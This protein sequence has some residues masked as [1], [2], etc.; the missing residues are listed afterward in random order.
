[1]T[2]TPIAVS[3]PCSTDGD[4]AMPKHGGRAIRK[5]RNPA[6]MSAS[7]TREVRSAINSRSA[8]ED[9]HFAEGSAR[10]PRP[11]RDGAKRSQLC[12]GGAL[13][14]IDPPLDGP[15]SL[16]S[17]A[18]GRVT[19]SGA[20]SHA[21]VHDSATKQSTTSPTSVSS[22]HS[23][24]FSGCGW[25]LSV[26]PQRRDAEDAGADLPNSEGSPA[27]NETSPTERYGAERPPKPSLKQATH[28]NSQAIH[29]ANWRTVGAGAVKGLLFTASGKVREPIAPIDTTSRT[30][31]RTDQGCS[32]S[33]N[34]TNPNGIP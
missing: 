17:R 12:C 13:G 8:A 25:G 19:E 33:H 22:N 27:A 20:A 2:M 9:T 28:S 23:T 34:P 4:I 32:C 18:R 29:P 1:M 21:H 3:M 14:R 15:A 6:R 11:P 16:P 24:P 30:S 26:A 7:D 31:A 5:T 10:A